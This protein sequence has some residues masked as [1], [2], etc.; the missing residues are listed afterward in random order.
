MH[1]LGMALMVRELGRPAGRPDDRDLFTA[2]VGDH[3]K[4]PAR[5]RRRLAR[6]S[7][8]VRPLGVRISLR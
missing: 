4:R 1:V 7:E 5:R 2:L 3:S 8:R 6:P